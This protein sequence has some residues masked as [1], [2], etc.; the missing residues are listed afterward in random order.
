MERIPCDA[1][2]GAV[3]LPEAR[4]IIP[5]RS[6]LCRYPP[7]LYELWNMHDF[8]YDYASMRE[9]VGRV[10]A[11]HLQQRL[12]IERDHEARRVG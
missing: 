6:T 11:A 8:S 4:G 5:E 9:L 3:P 12:R 10:S 2:R 1:D 7:I